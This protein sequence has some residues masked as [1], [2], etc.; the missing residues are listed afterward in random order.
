MRS[1]LPILA[2]VLALGTTTLF[3]LAIDHQQQH[4]EVR[5]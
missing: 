4:Q 2:I 5:P 3:V 1:L